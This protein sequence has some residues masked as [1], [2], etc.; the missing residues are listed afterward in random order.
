MAVPNGALMLPAFA[1]MVPL[2]VGQIDGLGRG[3]VGG[4]RIKGRV[5]RRAAAEVQSAAGAGFRTIADR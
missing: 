1:V 4:K 3:C 2:D 5:H